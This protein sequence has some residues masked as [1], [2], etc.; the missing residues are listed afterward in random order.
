MYGLLLV[1]HLVYEIALHGIY[2][3]FMHNVF[4]LELSECAVYLSEYFQREVKT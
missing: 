1:I 4:I 2:I 3:F